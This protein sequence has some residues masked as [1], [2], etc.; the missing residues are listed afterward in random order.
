MCEVEL[1]LEKYEWISELPIAK[2]KV[3]ARKSTPTSTPVFLV[4]VV[5]GPLCCLVRNCVL[6]IVLPFVDVAC[7][8]RLRSR[9]E[10]GL[11]WR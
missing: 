2:V 3:A 5:V 4:D 8:K 6:I 10:A 11:W 1:E 7:M 9:P